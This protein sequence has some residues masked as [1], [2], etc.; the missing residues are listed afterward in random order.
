M[1]HI[2]TTTTVTISTNIEDWLNTLAES[3]NVAKAWKLYRSTK[4][5]NEQYNKVEIVIENQEYVLN[6]YKL[7]H[8]GK[9][10]N[11]QKM[12]VTEQEKEH[13]RTPKTHGQKPWK[14]VS[15]TLYEVRAFARAVHDGNKELK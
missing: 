10:H 11:I 14:T 13:K 2:N 8:D 5:A 7:L 3:L 9:W 12:S 1:Q 15:C 6:V 4:L